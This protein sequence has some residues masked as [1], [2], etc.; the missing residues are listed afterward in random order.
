ML[1]QRVVNNIKNPRYFLQKRLQGISKYLSDKQYVRLMFLVRVGYWPNLKTPKTFNEKQ[2][3]LKLHDHNPL[4]TMMADKYAVKKYVA[5][6]IGEEHV[7]PCYGVWENADEI[8]FSALPNQ[9]VL[10]CTH[11]SGGGMCICRDKSK[12]D[13]N[14]TRRKL[15][16]G[17]KSDFY[18]ISRVWPYKDIPRRILADK[19][20]DDHM[21][22]ELRDYK[23]WCFNGVPRVM[24]CTNKGKQ[25]YEN[26]YDMD[27]RPL[28]ISHGFIHQVPEF[29]RPAAFE[30]MKELASKL[31]T[32]IP[33]V[34][35]DFFYVDGI[36]Y[37]GEFTFY[38][39]GGFKAFEKKQTDIELG[40]YIDL[41]AMLEQQ[42]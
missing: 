16:E 38:D 20:L 29:D 1:V 33:F 18:S 22:K 10:K 39:W 34:R 42:K 4:Y 9:F 30:E 12:L 27:F 19:F 2:N 17:L 21:G 14:E 41:T 28:D 26:F 35:I 40:S 5:D 36:V 7:V 32:G 15:N 24:Y 13:M 37:F 23:F 3:W 8:N 25:I 11:N 6:L 31:S